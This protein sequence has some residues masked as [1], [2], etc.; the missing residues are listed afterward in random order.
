[1]PFPFKSSFLFILVLVSIVFSGTRILNR[2]ILPPS[3][4]KPGFALDY[5]LLNKE[6][7]NVVGLINMDNGQ[8]VITFTYPSQKWL[9]LSGI[10][11]GR[12]TSP[13]LSSQTSFFFEFPKRFIITLADKYN[14]TVLQFE[15]DKYWLPKSVISK[16]SQYPS[17]CPT[18]GQNIQDYEG[19]VINPEKNE[20]RYQL[21]AQTVAATS[22]FSITFN[23]RG[24]FPLTAIREPPYL[25]NDEVQ[26]ISNMPASRNVPIYDDEMV[27]SRK[28][29][30]EVD[31]LDLANNP[32][33]IIN[34][35][36]NF[37]AI[38]LLGCQIGKPFSLVDTSAFKCM[39]FGN[40]KWFSDKTGSIGAVEVRND[41]VISL[42]MHSQLTW[43]TKVG[44]KRET[45]IVRVLGEPDSTWTEKIGISF[46]NSFQNC[47]ITNYNYKK[48]RML[49]QFLGCRNEVAIVIPSPYN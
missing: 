38:N 16:I 28:A 9:L 43:N 34:P 21:D 5:D 48:R 19:Q 32:G 49:I 15:T 11:S 7:K 24:T 2:I 31:S 35:D 3:Q 47:D 23:T 27:S 22:K 36:I 39:Y 6:L 10:K 20:L 41:T 17:L 4:S 1:M 46:L 42:R 33:L 13:D 37:S 14:Q 8:L 30:V 26:A 12:I 25:S 29:T 40:N 18:E 44:L 45:S